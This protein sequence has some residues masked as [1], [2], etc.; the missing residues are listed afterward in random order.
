LERIE[1][2]ES[3]RLDITDSRKHIESLE[4]GP[5]LE[6]ATIARED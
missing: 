4:I 2:P 3:S 6:R 1:K 5:I